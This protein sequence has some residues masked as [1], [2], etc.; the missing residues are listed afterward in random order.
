MTLFNTRHLIDSSYLVGKLYTLQVK[1]KSVIKN[2]F[3]FQF[4]GF[5]QVNNLK[6]TLNRL[7]FTAHRYSIT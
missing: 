7:V 6:Q 1:I 3:L 2:M 4:V 5:I